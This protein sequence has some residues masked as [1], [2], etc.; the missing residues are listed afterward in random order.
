M[1]VFG[2]YYEHLK[3][4]IS[5]VDRT[6]VKTANEIEGAYRGIFFSRPDQVRIEQWIKKLCENCCE[7]M[8]LMKNRNK[9][10]K[11][12]KTCILDLKRFEGVFKKMPPS[13][14]EELRLI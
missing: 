6:F 9:Y 2:K 10:I 13:D 12:M 1:K 4:S 3:P 5:K 7:K 8:P 14:G 11:L